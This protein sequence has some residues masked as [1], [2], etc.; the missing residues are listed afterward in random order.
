MQCSTKPKITEYSMMPTPTPR[1]PFW[2]VGCEKVQGSTMNID[3][4]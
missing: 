4:K 2:S 1:S 3:I